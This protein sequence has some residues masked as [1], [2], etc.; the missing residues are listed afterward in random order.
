MIKLRYSFILK[1]GFGLNNINIYMNQKNIYWL[2]T[3]LKYFTIF[4][5]CEISFY[6]W[7]KIYSHY[8]HK[9]MLKD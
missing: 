9:T 3:A 1:S 8:Y 4:N 2:F 5:D 6:W 7:D